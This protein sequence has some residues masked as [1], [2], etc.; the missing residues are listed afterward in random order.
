VFVSYKYGGGSGGRCISGGIGSS[1]RFLFS[2]YS[3]VHQQF[4]RLQKVVDTRLAMMSNCIIKTH[5]GGIDGIG[6][7]GGMAVYSCCE[8]SW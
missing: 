8:V 2:P 4:S 3:I 6:R 1:V 5:Y 7:S